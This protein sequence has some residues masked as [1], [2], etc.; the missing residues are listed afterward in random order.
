MFLKPYFVFV[1]LFLFKLKRFENVAKLVVFFDIVNTLNI[2]V[3]A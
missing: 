2:K 1:C 3:I